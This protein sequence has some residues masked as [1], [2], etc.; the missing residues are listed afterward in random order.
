MSTHDR[1]QNKKELINKT[2]EVI[3]KI[4]RTLQEKQEE[5]EKLEDEHLEN[6]ELEYRKLIEHLDI[7]KGLWYHYNLPD[8]IDVEYDHVE[9]IRNC[10]RL[11]INLLEFENQYAE[12][13]EK[14]EDGVDATNE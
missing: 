11:R 10:G 8:A 14:Q 5:I 1:K 9:Y 4:S 6:F 7:T 3:L 12:D 13:D 2:Q